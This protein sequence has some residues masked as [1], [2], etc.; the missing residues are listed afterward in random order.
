ME[1]RKNEIQR[2]GDGLAE[3][4]AAPRSQRWGALLRWLTP[5]GGTLILL[6]VFLVAQSVG[7]IP[8]PVRTI[9]PAWP[10]APTINYQGRL[11]DSAGTPINDTVAMQFS[12]YD[13]PSAG[14]VLWGPE[15]HLTVPV[16]DGLFS[17]GLGSQTTCGIPTN[18]L[19]GDV[20]LE[21]T[22]DGETLSPREQ[23]RAVPYAMQARVALTV[24]DGSI[25]T[26]QIADGAVT[27]DK[28]PSLLVSGTASNVKVWHGTAEIVAQGSEDTLI[29]TVSIPDSCSHLLKV[30]AQPYYV[31]S[32]W[33]M[34]TIGT[35]L[36]D[37]HFT[38]FVTRLSGTWSTGQTQS[39]DW[40]ALCD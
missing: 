22:V 1:T 29:K 2:L 27:Q 25:G 24:P 31:Y 8:L 23:L 16:S 32:P 30:F 28:A 37:N 10:A 17:V 3:R 4:Q 19:S 6:A 13:D 5:N 33:V 15:S 18:V 40:F 21:I 12:L 35:P 39:F 38:V 34:A 7:A 20:W 14:S 9:A 11:A 36:G 26:A